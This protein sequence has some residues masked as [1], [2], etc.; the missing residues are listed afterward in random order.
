MAKADAEVIICKGRIHWLDGHDITSDR[1]GVSERILLILYV[2]LEKQR[3]SSQSS[4]F[5]SFIFLL[6]SN[7]LRNTSFF[8]NNWHD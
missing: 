7:E 6:I 5:I 3:Y 8:V 2:A 1:I 4:S